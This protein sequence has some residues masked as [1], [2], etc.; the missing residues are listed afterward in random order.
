MKRLIIVI[1]VAIVILNNFTDILYYIDIIT[2]NFT[3]VYVPLNNLY[4]IPKQKILILSMDDRNEK[5]I[6]LHKRSWENYCNIHEFTFLFD[7]PCT[8]LPIYYCKFQ[9]IKS[10]M[11]STNFDYYIFVDSDTIVNK[12]F[13]EFPL[14]SMIQSVGI[15]T[16]LIYGYLHFLQIM[17]FLVG[18]FYIFKKDEPTKKLLQDCIDYVDFSQWK[19][20][21][22][23]KCNYSGKCYEE[24]ALFYS[25]KKNKIIHK[26]ITGKFI[27]NKWFGC[28][29]DYFIIHHPNKLT[30]EECF[31]KNAN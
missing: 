20:L 28:Q 17:K 13:L 4:S 8:N 27:S 5:F 18:S 26:R 7:K 25:L 9:K 11:N 14:E 2:S 21:K 6:E 24:A 30:V 19:D 1:I 3:N 12:K 10:L 16:Q 23:G 29:T 22:H 31:E 15:N